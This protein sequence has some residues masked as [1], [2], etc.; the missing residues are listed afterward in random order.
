MAIIKR[1]LQDESAFIVEWIVGLAGLLFLLF[2]Y[3]LF[4]P[5]T[6]ILILNFAE[7]GAPLAQL[8]WIKQMFTWGFLV[9]GVLCIAYPFVSAY[10][11]TYDQ[12]KA[13]GWG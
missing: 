5:V 4:S 1:F 9:F 3:T 11:R 8:M 6:N 13:G 10:R 12:G 7:N 2:A